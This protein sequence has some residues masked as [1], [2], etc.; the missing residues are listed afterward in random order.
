MGQTN[1]ASVVGIKMA[2]WLASAIEVQVRPPTI[3]T[4]Q[5]SDEGGRQ[6]HPGDPTCLLEFALTSAI[7]GRNQQDAHFKQWCGT[8]EDTLL[9]MKAIEPRDNQHR[10]MESV[11]VTICYCY[12]RML[13]QIIGIV[14]SFV[15]RNLS[16]LPLHNNHNNHNK[17]STW[18][19]KFKNDGYF[20]R[21]KRRHI[22]DKTGLVGDK[23]RSHDNHKFQDFKGSVPF[24]MK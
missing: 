5:F 14:Q 8:A 4:D 11:T 1:Y 16:T 12:W 15:N 21:E 6:N 9:S 24:P 2:I 13:L 3:V 22:F 18:Q 19:W 17:Q 23:P 20:N 10:S 7:E